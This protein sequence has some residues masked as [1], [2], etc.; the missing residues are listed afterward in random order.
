MENGTQTYS[1][2]HEADSAASQAEVGDR[3]SADGRGK[4]RTVMTPGHAAYE[5]FRKAFPTE[6]WGPWNSSGVTDG[7][8]H[9]GWEAVARAAI[10]AAAS[11]M[12]AQRG[13]DAEQPQIAPELVTLRT[14]LEA[15]ASG[16]ERHHARGGRSAVALAKLNMA[17]MIREL[18]EES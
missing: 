15:F 6:D 18:L 2:P 7:Q 5:A 17:R 14:R 16:L 1:R 3:V 8:G 10:G 9:G 12:Q 13:L 11:G 4:G